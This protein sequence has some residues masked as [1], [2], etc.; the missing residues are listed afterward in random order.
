MYKKESLYEIFEEICRQ[1]PAKLALVL[2]EEEVSY[3]ALLNRVITWTN[4]F[5][6]IGVKPGDRVLLVTD[7][8]Y[9]FIA[10]WFSLWKMKCIPVPLEPTVSSSELECAILS[11]KAHWVCS[12]NSEHVQA[13]SIDSR[14]HSFDIHPEWI[15][16]KM[17][18]KE[19]LE[20]M[21]DNAFYVYTSGT[22]GTPKCVIYDHDA[23]MATVDSLFDAYIM[24]EKD[25]VLTPLTPTLPATMFTVILP[26]LTKG[27]TLVMPDEPIPGLIL[28]LLTRTRATV[29]FAVPYFYNLLIDAI[30]V[31]EFSDWENLRLCLSTSAFLTKQTF[32]EFYEL[33]HIPIRSIF[34]TS[35]AMYCTFNSS[36]DP[37]KLCRSVGKPQKGVKIKVI[38]AE[39]KQLLPLQEGQII[40]SGTHLSK[41][42]FNR[43]ELEE[44]VYRNGW[45]Y[46]GD[47]GYFDEEGNLY[48]TGRLSE[49]I[50]VGG[51][52]VN[53][54]E[55]EG[56]LLSFPGVAEALIT[57][58]NDPMV[59]ESIIGKIVI[60][61][62]QYVHIEDLIQHCKKVLFHYK[63]PS[64]IDVVE[65]L[66][67]SR[68]GKIRRLVEEII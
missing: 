23:S 53:P 18:L 52:L 32:D 45:V 31:R 21:P 51:Y 65:E 8:R 3:E 49:T 11:S 14:R 67:K 41:G 34:C 55:V 17:N 6:S 42:Y 24:T 27:A 16:A 2:S 54:Q 62:G 37:E 63:V 57:A 56:I 22:T 4:N 9:D 50:N 30:K 36:D 20:H 19:T 5:I 66:P 64:R 25:V 1:M 39:D 13:L 33:S 46:T 68:Y 44:K 12:E 28:K 60:K 48:I 35:E 43:P 7:H 47:M 58:E 59:G 38:D 26:T 40:V 61:N 15:I 10:I 29:F